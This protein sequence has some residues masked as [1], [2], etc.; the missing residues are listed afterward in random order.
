MKKYINKP[1][2]YEIFIVK[3]GK[4]VATCRLRATIQNLMPELKETMREELGVRKVKVL[5]LE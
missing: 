2:T 3:T 5:P 4:V 1:K